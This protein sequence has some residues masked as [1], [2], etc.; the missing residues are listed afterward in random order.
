MFIVGIYCTCSLTEHLTF[1]LLFLV[2]FFATMN[3]TTMVT[4]ICV[5]LYRSFSRTV[6][7]M[8]GVTAPGGHFGICEAYLVM[9]V[10]GKALLGSQSRPG[11]ARYS[12]MHGIVLR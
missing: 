10:I 8:G 9:S 1:F 11:D 3:K 6:V 2:L 7:P 4:L 12:V 5:S